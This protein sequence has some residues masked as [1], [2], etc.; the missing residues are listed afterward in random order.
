VVVQLVGLDLNAAVRLPAGHPEELTVQIA[1]ALDDQLGVGSQFDQ[2]LADATD[3]PVRH[4][5][6]RWWT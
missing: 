5:A 4:A 1:N 6:A 2:D 3:R